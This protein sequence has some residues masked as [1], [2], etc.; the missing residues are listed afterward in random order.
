MYDDAFPNTRN[1]HNVHNAGLNTALDSRAQCP[2]PPSRRT[3]R[4]PICAC[5]PTLLTT[6][7][8]ASTETPLHDAG[9]L[10]ASMVVHSFSTRERRGFG[11]VGFVGIV[12]D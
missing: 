1:A 9:T 11:Y 5:V 3:T 7:F 10:E 2:S 8:F 6:L 12:E 4:K